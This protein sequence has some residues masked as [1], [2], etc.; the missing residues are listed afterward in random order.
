[1]PAGTAYV[2]RTLLALSLALYAAYYLQLD[3]PASAGTTAIILASPVRGAILSKS[4]WRFVGTAVG[5]IFAVV[6]VALFAQSPV[7]F[8]AGVAIWLGLCTTLATLLQYFRSYAAVLAGYTVTLIAFS[9]QDDPT[10]IFDVALG[11]VSVVSVGIMATAFVSV[12]FQPGRQR[13]LHTGAHPRSDR[14]R[15]GVGGRFLGRA[16][17]ADAAA[18]PQPDIGGHQCARPDHRI[19]GRGQLRGGTACRRLAPWRW[20][21]CSPR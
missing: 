18:G 17:H 7:L 5:A 11:R 15:G 8:V 20:P 3:S 12:L 21:S 14:R 19:C 2:L 10:R 9:V 4:V 16:G 1:M 6:L 13:W